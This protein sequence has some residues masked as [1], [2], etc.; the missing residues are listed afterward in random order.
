MNTYALGFQ[1]VG[2]VVFVNAV[3]IYL[4]G[5]VLFAIH[6]WISVLMFFIFHDQLIKRDRR[7]SREKHRRKK[8]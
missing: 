4:T 5:S 7:R 2:I 1:A 8:S 6:F 3:L